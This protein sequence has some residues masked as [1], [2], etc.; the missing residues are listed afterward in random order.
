MLIA[1][2]KWKGVERRERKT[3]REGGGTLFTTVWELDG[4]AV[5]LGYCLHIGSF[6]THDITMVLVRNY[7]LNCD[8]GLLHNTNTHTHTRAKKETANKHFFS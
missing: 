7:A 6:G 8:L 5:L 2:W 1:T 4:D 3:E